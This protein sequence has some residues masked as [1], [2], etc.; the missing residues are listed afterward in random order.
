MIEYNRQAK[1]KLLYYKF[2]LS[3]LTKTSINVNMQILKSRLKSREN[4]DSEI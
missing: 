3:T 4:L 2:C 1:Y